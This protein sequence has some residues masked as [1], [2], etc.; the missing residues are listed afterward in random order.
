MS[1]IAEWLTIAAIDELPVGER[2]IIDHEDKHIM[3]INFAGD[4]YAIESMCT[5]AM[6]ELDDA[7]VENCAV[8]CPLH[9]AHFCLKTGEPLSPPAFEPIETY[10]LR[11]NDGKIEIAI[12]E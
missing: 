8:V 1:A 9:G 4:F 11:I 2:K 5:H 7:E 10:P 6:F 12:A 3:L